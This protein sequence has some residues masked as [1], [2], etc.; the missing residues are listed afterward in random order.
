MFTS[1]AVGAVFK[2]LDE[3]SP[4]LKKILESVR[5]LNKAIT[6]TRDNLKGLGA[7][8]GLGAAIAET[9]SLAAAWRN[10]GESAAAA[11]KLVAASARSAGAAAATSVP[12]VASPGIGGGRHRPG[13]FGGSG[14][15][16]TGPGVALPGGSHVRVGGNTAMVTGGAIGYGI[17]EDAQLMKDIH[18]INYHL[19]RADTKENVA[20]VRKIL[21]DAM[22]S[23][24]MPMRDIAKSATDEARLLKGTPGESSGIAALPDFLRAA[25]AEALAKDT[26]MDEAM[27]SIIGLAHMTKAYD[28][29]AIHKL[30]P[31]FAYLSTA[32]PAGLKEMERSFSYAVPILQSGADVDPI[33]AMLLGTA[34]STA[35]VTS[36]KSGTWLREF[37]VRSM[38]G[39]EATKAGHE[40]N[41]M[42]R[43]FGL[44]DANGRPTYFVN[45]KPDPAKALEIAG[46]I[47]AA[48]PPEERLPAEMDLFGRRGAGAFSVLADAKVLERIKALRKEKDSPEFAARY[49]SILEDY[50]GTAVGT[51][52]TTLAEFNVSL[53]RL[54]DTVLPAVTGALRDFSSVLQ[55]IRAL[56]PGTDASKGAVG[57]RAIEG[58][59]IGA[60]LGRWGLGP[61]GAVI[62]AAGG[63]AIV[64][65][66]DAL[67]KGIDSIP[68]MIN[69]GIDALIPNYFKNQGPTAPS[70][71]VLAPITLNLNID[72]QALA[73]AQSS[74]SANTFSSQA[75]AFDGLDSFVGGDHQHSD[76]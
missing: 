75:P 61:G 19:G 3:A 70:K 55:G 49:G 42:L 72:G 27:K 36:S 7:A 73:R 50:R 13:W 5:E 67:N 69:K 35:G 9:D 4:G 30:V 74:I 43:R 59:G 20:Q 40:H 31:A 76:K 25:A 10:V 33:E 65:G 15:H 46:P 21:E 52:K 28:F 58:A 68:T 45:G 29:A 16:V 38:P 53:M 8:P 1:Y 44:V 22:I 71:A 56:I 54:G 14:A 66:A 12:S 39:D 48:M 57:T 41:E 62:G 24:G 32:N 6:L 34:L 26:T 2:I 23:T 11:A 37:V 64:L 51:A 47:A 60:L 17:Y 18:W 63:A